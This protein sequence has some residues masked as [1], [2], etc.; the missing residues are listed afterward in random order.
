[1]TDIQQARDV[2]AKWREEVSVPEPWTIWHDLNHQGFTT[3]GDDASY[4]EVVEIGETDESNPTAHVYVAEDARLIVG[5][6]GNPDL[7]DAIDDVLVSAIAW[8]ISG[9]H[10]PAALDDLAAA[11]IAA[12]ER[13]AS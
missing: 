9:M 7:L 12:D 10:R 2:L 11:I 13:M 8:D 3:I 1:V 6:A 5:T 4:R